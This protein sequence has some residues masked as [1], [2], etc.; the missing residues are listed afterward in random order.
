MAGKWV[1]EFR[2]RRICC[3]DFLDIVFFEALNLPCIAILKKSPAWTLLNL[4]TVYYPQLTRLFYINLKA[5]HTDDGW[6][7]ESVVKGVRISFSSFDFADFL[8][9]P[10]P[11][12][13]SQ[14]NPSKEDCITL[15]RSKYLLPE[16]STNTSKQLTHSSLTLEAKIIFNI[17]VRCLLPRLNSGSLLT[18][19]AMIL[20]YRILNGL[21]L[22]LA[23]TILGSMAHT[24]KARKGTPLPFATLLTQIFEASGIDFKNEE[25][26]RH[27]GKFD[28]KS[29]EKIGITR[30]PQGTWSLASPS[31]ALPTASAID[32][33]MDN[34]ELGLEEVRLD[35]KE[36]HKE[37]MTEMS[38]VTKLLQGLWSRLTD[39][40]PDDE[41]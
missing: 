37:F 7:L 41:A 5:K 23:N 20:L 27:M 40:V 30:S 36:L 24:R 6:F 17:I 16:A 25:Q 1:D 4:E 26:Q 21:D 12:P 39:D 33:R 29:L 3:S 8:G 9:L 11:C 15:A 13:P 14:E 38:G 22:D 2:T 28:S 35:I 19:N 31:K 18:D 10:S 32:E 34:L